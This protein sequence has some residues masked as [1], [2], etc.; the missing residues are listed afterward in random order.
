VIGLRLLFLLGGVAP[1][2]LYP[3][4]AV[5]LEARGFEPVAIG[6]VTGASSLVFALSVPGWS[7][8]ADVRLG[9]IGA[10]RIVAI[11]AALTMVTF[12][13]S[14]P[15][16]VLAG[17]AIAYAAFQAPIGPLS[18]ALA[19][20][21]L[22][23]PERG[24]GRI[25]LLTSLAF[26]VTA[27]V[28]GLLYDRTG[29]WPATL[30]YAA[31][32]IGIAISLIWVPDVP[33][34]NLAEF[35]ADERRRRGGSMRVAL[36]IQPRLWPVMLA[37]FLVHIGVIA[38]FTYLSLRIVDLGGRPSDVAL[39]A[40][41]GSFAE[42]PGM[43]LAGRVAGRIG[44]RGLFALSS[45]V[46]GA[47]L[48]SWVFIGDPTVIVVTRIFT[49]LGFAG[50]WVGAVLSMRVLLPERLQA[51]GQGLYQMVAFGVAALVANMVGGVVYASVGSSLVFGGGA[52][53][54]LVA[55]V[56]TWFSFPT[57]GEQPAFPIGEV[58]VV[59]EPA[60]VVGD[61]GGR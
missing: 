44:L 39:S 54:C 61:A 11:G 17:M 46:Y 8:L 30:I 59:P 21:A 25:R 14:W 31:A 60:L 48:L 23:D 56:V 5:M 35:G 9:R 20:N 45:I 47:S 13:L 3:F 7:H 6:L 34:A 49:G 22:E 58:P 42:I 26:A 18:D 24:Y 55:A 43:I 40:A 28:A 51:T 52:I 2:A 4:I 41:V 27:I 12:G 36:T 38:G 10:L 53:L 37:I 16:L 15:P 29:Y 19:V 50:L 32:T 1:G 57:R 33:R